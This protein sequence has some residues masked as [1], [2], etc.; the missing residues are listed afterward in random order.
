MESRRR[1]NPDWISNPYEVALLF[2]THELRSEWS[3]KR[4]L[5]FRR[6]FFRRILATRVL[7][8]LHFSPFYCPACE[9]RPGGHL[10]Y[11]NYANGN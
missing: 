6:R 3:R 7:Y 9:G 5:K 11:C 4:R 10:A 8:D 2:A 1:T